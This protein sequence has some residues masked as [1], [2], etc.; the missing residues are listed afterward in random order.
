MAPSKAEIERLTLVLAE[1]VG[2]LMATYLEERDLDGA[3]GDALAN[4]LA[5]CSHSPASPRAASC[6]EDEADHQE[7]ALQRCAAIEGYSLHANVSLAADHREGLLRLCRYG[8]RQSFSRKQLSE[9]EDGRLC[10]RLKRRWG[11]HGASALLLEPTQ[12]LHWLAA[13]L[14]P[15]YLNCTRYLRLFA[16]NA[17]RRHQVCPGSR[18]KRHR[19][20]CSAA[21]AALLEQQLDNVMPPLATQSP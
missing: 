5:L 14:P 17:N 15:P 9:L 16:P 10:Y 4:A 2:R 7:Q 20:R 21:Q 18:A 13:L 12:L 6:F 11:P 1:R 3:S 19:H 8:A